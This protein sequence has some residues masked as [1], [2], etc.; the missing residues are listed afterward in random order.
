MDW[1]CILSNT[2]IYGLIAFV[3]S[4]YLARWKF[5]HLWLWSTVTFI[6]YCLYA[7]S[8]SRDIKML[9]L[10][11]G[12]IVVS[13]FV[14]YVML[15][16]F[17]NEKQR[18]LF[19]LVF[20]FGLALLFENAIGYIFGSLS[21]SLTWLEFSSI[22]LFIIFVLINIIIRYIFGQ[23][24][25]GRVMKGVDENTKTIRSLWVN[26]SMRIQLLFGV[27]FVV[28]MAAALLIVSQS[29]LR[30]SDALFYMVKWVGL[31]ILVGVANK[32]YVM[33]WA[34]FYVL[35]EYLVFVV[36]AQP[37]A[38]KETLILGIILA[39]LLTKPEGLFSRS[40]RKN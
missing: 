15:K 10:M 24:Y 16:R 40:T 21:V 33:R 12:L 4:G 32:E 36:F 13:S 20:T 37:I 26:T 28:L 39:V 17:P 5:L 19:W 9:L 11:I 38:Y 23:S 34:L 35:V 2:L 31:M 8:A 29:H 25:F 1:W 7:Y 22:T 14:Y 6:G 30:A 27:F 3:Y 18:H